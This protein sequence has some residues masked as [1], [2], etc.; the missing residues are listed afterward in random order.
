MTLLPCGDDVLIYRLY[1]KR[2]ID[3]AY[4]LIYE[5]P[6]KSYTPDGGEELFWGC[7][8]VTAED[9]AK[10]VSP[11]SAD[12]CIENCPIFELPNVVTANN[13]DAN[14]FY[15]AIKVR[16]IKEIDL[17]IYDRWGNLV[18]HTTDPYFQW[19]TLSQVSGEPVSEG[20]FFYTCDVFEPR[21][22]GIVKRSIKGYMQVIR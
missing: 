3:S 7:F 4:R 18:Y 6:L 14:D 1:Y 13:D 20:T 8:A 17:N 19:N 21:L 11:L 16:Q 15:K 12:F 9:S 2:T 22:K 5:G 10:N